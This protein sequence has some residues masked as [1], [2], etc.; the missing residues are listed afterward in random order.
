MDEKRFLC[1]LG[2]SKTDPEMP[3]LH[4]TQKE[5]HVCNIKNIEEKGNSQL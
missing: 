5:A 1:A 2:N 3:E 4:C